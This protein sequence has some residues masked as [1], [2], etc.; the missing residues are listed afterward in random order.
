MT[1][2]Q[3]GEAPVS[4][5]SLGMWTP[6]FFSLFGDA[7]TFPRRARARADVTVEGHPWKDLASFERVC[8]ALWI[9]QRTNATIAGSRPAPQVHPQPPVRQ[10]EYR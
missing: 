6:P 3:P 8:H 10:G 4:L 2:R 7:A 1:A 9:M 5:E